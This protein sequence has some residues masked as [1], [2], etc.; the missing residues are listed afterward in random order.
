MPCAPLFPPKP[1]LPDPS[2][3][4]GHPTPGLPTLGARTLSGPEFPN[5]GFPLCCRLVSSFVALHP[6]GG[7]V[8]IPFRW[9][10]ARTPSFR[11]LGPDPLVA[12]ASVPPLRRRPSP[13]RCQPAQ[14]Q[15]P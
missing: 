15:T 13:F 12:P 14:I 3:L 4:S 9:Q 8:P 10:P 1:R 5:P 7:A 11:T 6:V 2:G